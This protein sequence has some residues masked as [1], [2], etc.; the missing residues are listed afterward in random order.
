MCSN[1]INREEVMIVASWGVAENSHFLDR[2]VI[3]TNLDFK[4]ISKGKPEEP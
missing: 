2:S 4:P 1:L 3:W